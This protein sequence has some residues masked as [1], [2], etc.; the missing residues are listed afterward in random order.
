MSSVILTSKSKSTLKLIT[1][2]AK[3]LGVKVEL[4]QENKIP[5]KLT[6]QAMEELESGKSHTFSNVDELFNELQKP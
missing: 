5:N 4:V 3:K 6:T 1:D 2:L